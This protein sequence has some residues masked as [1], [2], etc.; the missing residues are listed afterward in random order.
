MSI[1]GDSKNNWTEL[2]M[3]DLPDVRTCVYTLCYNEE[4][5]LPFF[6][7]HYLS[8][9]DEVVVYDNGSTDGSVKVINSFENTR[10]V[11]YNAG[12]L[13][14]DLHVIMKDNIWKEARGRF[15]FVVV[16]DADEFIYSPDMKKLLAY[17]K[18]TGK[19]ILH[20]K[21][22]EMVGENDPGKEGMIYDHIKNGIY[23][24]IYDKKAVFDPNS[25]REINYA[26][27][28]HKAVPRGRVKYF[29]SPDLKLLHY[30]FLSKERYL[31]KIRDARQSDENRKHNY[32][33][34]LDYPEE[35]HVKLYEDMLKKAVPVV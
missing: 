8:F 13:R 12:E 6:L 23:N 24:S 4:I 18:K 10:I 32:G 20:P 35:Y 19:T 31:K 14:D 16:V 9:C 28:A 26:P 25:I 21:G 1:F 17:C 29:R 5:I 3:K 34:V 33:F 27:G 15:D 11:K 7:R 22:Y 2:P 30:K